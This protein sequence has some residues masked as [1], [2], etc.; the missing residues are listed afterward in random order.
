MTKSLERTLIAID[1]HKID[2]SPEAPLRFRFHLPGDPSGNETDNNLIES[3]TQHGIFVPPLLVEYTSISDS[4]TPSAQKYQA[5]QAL[6][7]IHGF[8]RIAAARRAGLDETKALLIP[9]GVLS[10]R[11]IITIR[12]EEIPHGEPLSELEKIILMNKAARFAGVEWPGFLE[13]M[14]RAVGQKLSQSFFD[15]VCRLLE[16]EPS[17]LKAF[18]AG[19]VSTADLLMLSEHPSI[20]C[21]EAVRLLSA[22]MLNRREQKEAV[23][24][25]LRIADQ[26]KD[27]WNGFLDSFST[28]TAPLLEALKRHCYPK[29]TGDTARIDDIVRTI[30][31]PRW[32][33]IHTPDNL[34]GRYFNLNIQIRDE[35]SLAAVIKKLQDALDAG[36]IRALLDIMRGKE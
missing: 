7:L 6:L 10:T 2:I 5:E 30:R 1:P 19:S 9:D 17:I 15:R 16:L 20:D 22:E 31:L 34:E 12:L 25:M 4:E 24:L 18:H 29:L 3:V 33:A 26:G 14:S 13:G 11:E 27:V 32:S 23:K 36:K 8:R 21:N 35:E 28:E